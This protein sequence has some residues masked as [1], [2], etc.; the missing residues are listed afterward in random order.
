MTSTE[1]RLAPEHS[2]RGLG[3]GVDLDR[4]VGVG[5]DIDVGADVGSRSDRGWAAR[6]A[7]Q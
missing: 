3:L 1:S 2:H 5:D 7:R 6:R 4:G